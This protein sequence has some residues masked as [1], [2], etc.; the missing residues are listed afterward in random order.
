MSEPSLD[1]RDESLFIQQS[2]FMMENSP[3]LHRKRLT[4]LNW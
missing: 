1:E 2:D 4:G 3:F